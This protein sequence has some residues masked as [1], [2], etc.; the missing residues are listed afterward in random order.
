MAV[1][2]ATIRVARTTRDLLAE[3]AHERGVSLA[4]LLAEIAR[5]R[6]LEAIFESERQARLADAQNPAVLEEM[7]LW[8]STLED[9]IDF[10][11]GLSV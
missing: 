10:D 8:E 3:Q 7:R 6:E 9:G 4:A 1:D 2:T 11:D 5:E